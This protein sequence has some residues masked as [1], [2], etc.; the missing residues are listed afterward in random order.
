MKVVKN[1]RSRKDVGL[2]VDFGKREFNIFKSFIY[3]HILRRLQHLYF[4]AFV[5]RQNNQSINKI[6]IR[7]VKICDFLPLNFELRIDPYLFYFHD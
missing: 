6:V 4:A 2:E 7:D 1:R 5:F 3:I